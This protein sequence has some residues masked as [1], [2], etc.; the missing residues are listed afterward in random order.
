MN[1]IIDV[2]KDY[3]KVKELDY[4]DVI[5]NVDTVERRVDENTTKYILRHGKV[6][7]FTRKIIERK[8]YLEPNTPQA[9]Y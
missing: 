8:Y 1:N 6:V 4:E 9:N 2:I 7:I 5:R 3:V